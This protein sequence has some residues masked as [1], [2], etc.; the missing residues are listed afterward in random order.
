[1]RIRMKMNGIKVK[2]RLKVTKECA[3]CI[4]REILS[5]FRKLY[6]HLLHIFGFWFGIVCCVFLYPF[7]F[8]SCVLF[9]YVWVRLLFLLPFDFMSRF[10]G[11]WQL[12][13]YLV[14][15][16]HTHTLSVCPSLSLSDSFY[17][18]V[19]RNV[20]RRHSW[21]SF[22]IGINMY[23]RKEKEIHEHTLIIMNIHINGE[24]E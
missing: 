2:R 1:M 24:D 20:C 22:S 6:T 5:M 19:C 8:S 9:L 4:W 12:L 14:H 15:G 13:L 7:F 3:N 23:L 16:E 18:V 21:P 10:I 11:V 17:I